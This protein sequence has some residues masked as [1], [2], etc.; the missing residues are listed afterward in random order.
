MSRSLKVTLVCHFGMW[1]GSAAHIRKPC[2]SVSLIPTR[3]MKLVVLAWLV[4]VVHAVKHELFKTCAQLGFCS[5][6]RHYARH[7]SSS[8]YA[9]DPTS[10]TISDT[11]VEARLIKKWSGHS[12]SLPLSIEGVVGNQLR[13]I[14]DED[15]TPAQGQTGLVNPRR[16]NETGNWAF[17]NGTVETQ[18]FRLAKVQKN[19]LNIEYGDHLRAEI[20]L[21]QFVINFYYDDELELSVNENNYLNVEHWREAD[22]TDEDGNVMAEELDFDMFVDSFKDLAADLK[23]LGPELVAI[24]FQF[25]QHRHLYGIPEHCDQFR[26]PLTKNGDPFRLYNVDIFEYETS[27]RLPMYGLVPFILA[28]GALSVGVFWVNAADTWVDIDYTKDQSQSHFMLEN[29]VI[30]FIVSIEPEI[31]AVNRQF[32]KVVGNTM[33]P[34]LF[35]LGYHQC[36]WNYNDEA[37]VLDINDKFDEHGIPYDAIWLDI[38]YADRKHY[39]T[40]QQDKFPDPARMAR[41]LDRTGRHL[42]VIVDPH[43]AT[44]YFAS[45]ELVKAGLAMNNSHGDTFYGHCWPGELVWVDSLNPKGQQYWARQYDRFLSNYTTKNVH[46]WNDMNEPSVF[47]GPETTAP[48][49]NLH[50]GNWEHRSIHNI[51]GLSLHEATYLAISDGVDRPFILT[52]LYYAGSQRTAAL[53][54]GDNL[55]TWEHLRTLV[56][57]LLTHN[58]VNYPFVGVDIGGFFGDPSPELLTRWFQT[59]IFYPF[60]RQHAHLDTRRREPWVAGGVYTDAMR[61]AIKLRYS[62][63][64]IWYTAFRQLAL[65]GTPV[66]K[67]LFYEVNDD[68]VME[69]EDQFFVGDLG[70]MVKP[71]MTAGANK[72][73]MY[74]PR[75][76]HKYIDYT[77]GDFGSLLKV[78]QPGTT[79]TVAAAIDAIPMVVRE[80]LAFFRK[81]RYRRSSRLMAQDPYTLTVVVDGAGN[82][83]GRLYVDDGTLYAYEHGAYIDLEVTATA[84]GITLDIVLEAVSDK[85]Y[86]ASLAQVTIDRIQVVLAQGFD[87][88]RLVS[89]VGKDGATTAAAYIIDGTTMTIT[90]HHPVAEPMAWTFARDVA[91]EL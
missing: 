81:M 54:F 85:D 33:L 25:K 13:V 28:P 37:D 11:K 86:L 15:R 29:G 38:E 63:L 49:D 56:L 58:V 74:I 9:I 40:W 75:G 12:V 23:P 88:I 24:D 64:P 7:V 3:I 48:K 2:V 90:A 55:P 82:A 21:A 50:F 69:I 61:N 8:H 73:K 77:N 68:A 19:Q 41:K 87:D 4:L 47:D 45:D 46:L 14:I 89:A 32:G 59:A 76:D 6:Q 62:M 35:S 1:D 65:L 79:V 16:Y 20:D 44:G 31:A 17:V 57:M 43:L 5:R 18:P 53:W 34:P 22:D 83:H 60:M 71:V 78:Y 36:R 51:Y 52:R 72:V 27:S 67:P 39:F 80:G 66:V 70:I 10:I 91:D 42:V 30:D 26:L 84:T